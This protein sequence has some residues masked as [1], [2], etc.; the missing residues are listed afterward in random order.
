MGLE[1]LTE[2][3]TALALAGVLSERPSAIDRPETAEA[4]EPAGAP[5]SRT[6]DE[7]GDAPSSG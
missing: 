7:A 3:Q 6:A 4:A 1:E 5:T 2:H